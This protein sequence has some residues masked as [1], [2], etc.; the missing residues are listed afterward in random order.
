MLPLSLLALD[1]ALLC[2]LLPL[3][4]VGLVFSTTAGGVS[5][6]TT[7]GSGGRVTSEMTKWVFVVTRRM[8]RYAPRFHRIFFLKSKKKIPKKNSENFP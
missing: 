1:G 6:T 2:F 5:T 7:T 3:R 8:L 4:F